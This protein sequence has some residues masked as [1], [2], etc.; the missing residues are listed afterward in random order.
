MWPFSKSAALDKSTSSG[1]S[2]LMSRVRAP[3]VSS[4]KPRKRRAISL[5]MIAAIKPAKASARKTWWARNSGRRCRN[6]DMA[7]RKRGKAADYAA[8]R[9]SMP[10]L[11]RRMLGD[12][13]QSRHQQPVFRLLV[14]APQLV[15]DDAALDLGIDVDQA[16]LDHL[17]HL[18]RT[19]RHGRLLVVGREMDLLVAVDVELAQRMFLQGF[20]IDE[21]NR[22]ADVAP[23]DR[24]R[25]GVQGQLQRATFRLRGHR[26]AAGEQGESADEQDGAHG[27]YSGSDTA[28]CRKSRVDSG[29]G[30]RHE[31]R[32]QRARIRAVG[33]GDAAIHGQARSSE[34]GR[35]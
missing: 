30:N 6:S 29:F 27:R 28:L 26:R 18:V 8:A 7:W 22:L 19:G 14:V 1:F 23:A 25:V 16:D 20:R 3:G 10:A 24:V 12:I 9:R 32:L 11:W 35:A 21:R 2:R 31:T 15:V 5:P 33:E 13:G 4:R 17:A 34:I